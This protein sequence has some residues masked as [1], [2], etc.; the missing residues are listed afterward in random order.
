MDSDLTGTA[1]NDL[2][3]GVIAWLT[4]KPLRHIESALRGSP[5][6]HLDCPRARYLVTGVIPL[7]LTFVVGLL[8]RV[9]RE[10]PRVIDAG[11]PRVVL[12]SLPTAIRRGF[13]VPAKLAFADVRRGLY[14]R[15][16]LHAAF[17]TELE[18]TVTAEDVDYA[19]L[20]ARVRAELAKR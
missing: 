6:E 19:A 12:E 9:S 20:V 10:I 3:P 5:E 16:Q 15:V 11:T 4:G 7:G 13:D 1:M 17:A 18:D 8:V 14:S 2:L